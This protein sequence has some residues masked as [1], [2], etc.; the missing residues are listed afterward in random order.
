MWGL[1]GKQ[2]GKWGEKTRA[3]VK[4]A[5]SSAHLFCAVKGTS[6]SELETRSS[7]SRLNGVG[8]P[9]PWVPRTP[10]RPHS[11]SAVKIFAKGKK[12]EVLC[13]VSQFGER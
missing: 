12:F 7:N 1:L 13:S 4:G 10:I 6:T 8:K 11:E 9:L 3:K 5:F 2:M